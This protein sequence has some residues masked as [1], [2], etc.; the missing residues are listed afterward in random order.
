MMMPSIHRHHGKIN[1]TIKV[2]LSSSEPKK[3]IEHKLIIKK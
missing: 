2:T 3:T 1:L